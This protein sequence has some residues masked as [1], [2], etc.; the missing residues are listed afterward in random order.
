MFLSL[1]IIPEEGCEATYIGEKVGLDNNLT[2]RW[3]LGT[4]SL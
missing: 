1:T 3:G 4:K 2:K